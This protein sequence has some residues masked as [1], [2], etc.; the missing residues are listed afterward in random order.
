MSSSIAP[1]LR[2]A[3]VAYEFLAY[4]LKVPPEKIIVCGR[5]IGSGPALHLTSQLAQSVQNRTRE[6]L[7]D[8]GLIYLL[9]G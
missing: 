7:L 3:R 2:H 5:S 6:E 1:I 9:V 4:E 8:D